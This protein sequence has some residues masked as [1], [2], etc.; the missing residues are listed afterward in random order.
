M[1]HSMLPLF[2][3]GFSLIVDNVRWALT[4]PPHPSSWKTQCHWLTRHPLLL[5]VVGWHF[6]LLMHLLSHYI[7]SSNFFFWKALKQQIT[8]LQEDLKRKETKW[9][10]AHG[11]LRSQIEML[12]KENTDLREEIKVM[13]RFRL[14]AWK[15]AEAIESSPKACQHMTA[16]KKDDSMVSVGELVLPNHGDWKCLYI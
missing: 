15:R 10:S 6:V 11:R 4:W 5:S 8:D 13:E 16:T 1:P 3:P 9:S 2:S 12:V 7:N 14:D